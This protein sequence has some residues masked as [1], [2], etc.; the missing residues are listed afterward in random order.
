MTTMRGLGTLTWIELK[1][2]VREP[3][4]AFF[5]LVFPPMLLVL[6]GAIF[7]NA[8]APEYG[9]R[10]FVDHAVPAYVALVIA[11]SAFLS[12]AVTVATYRE[13]GILRRL[14]VTPIAPCAVLAAQLV[15]MLIVT[16]LGTVALVAV[17]V[18]AFALR[19]T[20]TI[21]SIVAAFVVCSGALFALGMALAA[22]VPTV[23][24]AQT[25]GFVIFYPMIFLS[26]AALPRELLPQA[27]Q[28]AAAILP[29]THG[30]TL[31]QGMWQG[32]AWAGYVSD[33]AALAAFG[34]VAA[35]AAVRAFR[36]E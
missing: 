6:F 27:L 4:A 9:G 35:V 17:G 8:P 13:R 34:I 14:R 11:T 12:L 19:C 2:F 30:V 33:V 32:D 28:S 7:G 20:G 22:V 29:L 5:T 18:G 26:G 24:A 10:G 36:W 21:A 31:L 3:L 23:R 1:L 25:V 16:V 15:V